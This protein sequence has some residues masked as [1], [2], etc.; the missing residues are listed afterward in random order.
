MVLANAAS[1]RH[2]LLGD[3]ERAL[4]DAKRARR[5][6]EE[7]GDRARAAQCLE[8][9]AGITARRG[10][11]ATAQRM[12][13]Q[14]LEVLEESGNQFL[15]GQHLR[16][17]ALLLLDEAKLRDAN[18]TLDQAD[19]LCT[20]AGF[21]DLATELESIR[22]MVA[23]AMGRG[24]EAMDRTR[25]AVANLTPGVE[26]PY[27]VNHRHALAARAVGDLME[28]GRAAL[29][30]REDLEASLLG[31][32]AEVIEHALTQ[33]P[34]HAEIMSLAAALTP[35]TVQVYLPATEAPLGRSPKA[36]DLRSVTWTIG[37]PDDEAVDNPTETRRRR[38]LRLLTEAEARQAS[39]S[40]AA[41]A[42]VLDVSESTVRRD[43]IALRESGHDVATRG[44]RYR[45]S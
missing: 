18:D 27:L 39:P 31:L 2:N 26:R 22:A 25:R 24:T 43:L 3:D 44:S 37:H 17:L 32:P 28:A 35:Q 13:E 10:D 23:L 30:A 12:L 38:L 1:A 42:G 8:T 4:S 36:G 6:F 11:A 45:A 14:S 7:I 34:E 5:L 9:M 15:Q 33:V 41:L 16:S 20:N 21:E 29:R 19:R 40:I